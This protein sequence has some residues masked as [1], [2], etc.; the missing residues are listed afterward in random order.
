MRKFF[1]DD[2][3]LNLVKEFKRSELSI[4]EFA[5]LKNISRSTFRDW[6]HAYDNIG[7][8]FVRIKG[9]QNLEN[10]LINEENLKMNMLEPSEIAKKSRHFT[11]FDH[12]IVC[13]EFKGLKITTSLEQALKIL[14]TIN[15]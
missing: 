1:T 4:S 5:R 15:V 9:V 14:E 3:R 8:T 11:R 2:Q 6:V 13:I 12:S 7:G 10:A